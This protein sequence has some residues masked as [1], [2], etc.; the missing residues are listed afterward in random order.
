MPLS[1]FLKQL[2]KLSIEIGIKISYFDR[3]GHSITDTDII[4]DIESHPGN[5]EYSWSEIKDN[6]FKI[7]LN[8]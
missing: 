4:D 7:Y 6:T 8:M 3:Y 2:N 1:E 5:F